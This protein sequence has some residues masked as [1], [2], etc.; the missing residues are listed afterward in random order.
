MKKHTDTDSGER[1]ALSDAERDEFD[2]LQLRRKAF[3]DKK[4]A[5][6]SA[7]NPLDKDR[8]M[9]WSHRAV[10]G[11]GKHRAHGSEEKSMLQALGLWVLF[12]SI[13]AL[14]IVVTWVITH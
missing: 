14:L 10:R 7:P 1:D 12:L 4:R 11:M 13:V 5:R 8:S 3:M 6:L 2:A 9:D